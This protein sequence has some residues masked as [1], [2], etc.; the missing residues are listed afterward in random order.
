M[1]TGIPFKMQITLKLYILFPNNIYRFYLANYLVN[2]FIFLNHP[3]LLILQLFKLR[4][5]IV[6]V[7]YLNIKIVNLKL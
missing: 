4:Q 6:G 3:K 2:M 7:K 1:D 5:T